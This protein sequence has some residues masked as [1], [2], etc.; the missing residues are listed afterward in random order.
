MAERRTGRKGGT[1]GNDIASH[2]RGAFLRAAKM[3]EEDG[4]PLSL[5]ILEQL[6]EKPLDTLR[7]VAQFVPKEMLVE[8]TVTQQLE[9]LSDEALEREIGRLVREA[10]PVLAACG[11]EGE[12]SH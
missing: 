5:I 1:R 8:A 3:S 9:E 10:A 4:R 2:I 6:Q 11:A 12:T 7:T